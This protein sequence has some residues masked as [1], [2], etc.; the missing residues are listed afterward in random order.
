MSNRSLIN[1][2]FQI[3]GSIDFDDLTSHLSLAE[4]TGGPYLTGTLTAV[5]GS[6]TVTDVSNFFSISEVDSYLVTATGPDTDKIFR[7]LS[8]S[9]TNNAVIYPL[10]TASG[11]YSY[12]RYRYRNLEDDLNFL[13][14]IISSITGEINWH[15]I[16]DT[17]LSQTATHLNDST[18][19]LSEEGIQDIVSQ[20]L[21]PGTDISISYDDFSG[22]VTIS[23]TL[24]GTFTNHAALSNLDYASSG[25]TGFASSTELATLS[26]SLESEISE[27]ANL[28]HDHDDLYYTE[29]E[30]DSFLTTLSGAIIDQIPT[31][32]GTISNHAELN[33]LDYET[34]G[35]TGFQPAGD[36]TT[37]EDLLTISGSIVEQ[38]PTDYYTTGQVDTLLGDKQDVGDYATNTNLVLVSGS[39]QTQINNID[40]LPNQAGNAGKYLSTDG[41][42]PFWASVSGGGGTSDHAGLLNLDFASSGH[43]GFQPAGDYATRTELNTASGIIVSQ[44]PTD[45]YTTNEVNSLI[46]T[47]SGSLQSQIDA[48]D[49]EI[50]WEEI[51]NKPSVF[52]PDTHGNEAHT[53]AFATEDYVDT[54]ISTI[55]GGTFDHA[56]LVNLDFADSGHTGFQPSGDYTTNSDLINVSGTLSN[57]IADKADILHQHITNDITDFS[58]NVQDIV[59]ATLVPGNN[60]FITYNDVANTITISGAAGEGGGYTSHNLL[61]NLDFTN[62]GHTGFASSE[63]LEDAIDTLETS[64]TLTSGTLNTKIDNLSFYTESEI[65]ALFLAAAENLTSTSGVLQNQIDA[66]DTI[67]ATDASVTSVSGVLQADINIRSLSTHNHT[68]SSLSEKSYNSL[69]DK[70]TIP[71]D[72]YS[73]AVVDAKDAAVSGSLDTRI[74]ALEEDTVD[75]TEIQNKPATF[76]PSSH[77]HDD[78]YYTESEVDILLT[79]VSGNIINQIPSVSGYATEEY[80]DTSITAVS[81]SL[82]SQITLL[83]D[84]NDSG[85]GSTD[86]W[87]AEQILSTLIED[88][89]KIIYQNTDPIISDGDNLNYLIQTASGDIWCKDSPGYSEDV[90]VGGTPSSSDADYGSTPA[91]LFDND[92]NTVLYMRSLNFTT[93]P[94]WINYQFTAPESIRRIGLFPRNAYLGRFPSIFQV[95]AS[96]TGSFSGEETV[97]ASFNPE[98]PTEL[99]WYYFEFENSSSFTHYR[100]FITGSHEPGGYVDLSEVEMHYLSS[101]SW[102]K[103]WENN[104]VTQVELTTVSGHIVSQIPTDFYTTGQIDTLLLN[105]QD[106]GDYSTTAEL[107]TA[108]GILQ[109]QIDSNNDD[110]Q[111]IESIYTDT[112]EPTGFVNRSDSYLSFND[113]TE[114][115]TVSGTYS[116]YIH[117]VKHSISSPKSA[118]VLGA[119]LNLFYLD[120]SE[121]LQVTQSFSI[122][123][124]LRDN[125]YVAVVYWDDVDSKHIYFGDERHGIL[126]DWNLH[127]YH[128]LTEGTKYQSGLGLTDITSDINFEGVYNADDIQWT[129]SVIQSS[130]DDFVVSVA[131]N[132]TPNGTRSLDLTGSENN[133]IAQ[134]SRPAGNLDLTSFTNLEGYI[135]INLFDGSDNVSIYGWNTGTNSIVGNSVNISSYV[136]TSTTDEWQNFIIPLTDMNLD[137]ET[138]DAIRIQT[139]DS[140]DCYLDDIILY[141]SSN[142]TN[143]GIEIG[144][145]SGTIRD[146][147]LVHN[148]D[149]ISSGEEKFIVLYREGTNGWT[150]DATTSVPLITISGGGRLA[151]NYFNGSTWSQVIVPNNGYV[152]SHIFAT[153][154][155][156]YPIISVQ[157]QNSYTDIGAARDAIATEINSLITG[158]LPFEEFIAIGSLIAQT[159]DAYANSHKARFVYIDSNHTINWQDFRGLKGVST[160]GISVSSHHNLSNLATGD[161][162]PQYHNN[163]RGDARYYTQ[164]QITAISGTIVS[165]IPSDFNDLYYT[166]AELDTGQLDNR[167]Y[168]ENEITSLLAGKENVFSKNTAFNKNF[169]TISGTVCAGDD[170]R[171]SDSRT[172]VN[173]GNEAHT[174]IFITTSGV[175]FENLNINGDVGTNSSQV[176]SGDHSHTGVYDLAGTASSAVTSHENT[177]DHEIFITNTDLATTSGNIVSQIPTDYYTTG[178]VDGLISTISGSSLKYRNGRMFPVIGN[179]QN[180]TG[181]EDF[182]YGIDGELVANDGRWIT[183]FEPGPLMTDFIYFDNQMIASSSGINNDDWVT[184][185]IS[186]YSIPQDDFDFQFDFQF[187]KHSGSL[188]TS[189]D[190][191][192]ASVGSDTGWAIGV[193]WRSD[194]TFASYGWDWDTIFEEDIEY[195]GKVL[196]KLRMKRENGL[197]TVYVWN[198]TDQ[199]WEWDGNTDG[200]S[201][202]QDGTGLLIDEMYISVYHKGIGSSTIKIDNFIWNNLVVSGMPFE[203]LS[204]IW[205][206]DN[207]LI[208]EL[209]SNI[210]QVDSNEI[211]SYR[212][213]GSFVIPDDYV[214][215]AALTTVSGSLQEQIDSLDNLYATDLE[216]LTTSGVLQSNINTKADIDHNHTGVY[217]PIG[218]YATTADLLTLSGTLTEAINN[219]TVSGTEDTYGEEG[220]VTAVSGSN[221]VSVT[222]ASEKPDTSY[223]I[224]TS[225]INEV[226][227]NPSQYGFIIT[228]KQTTGFTVLFSSPF[229]SGNYKLNFRVGPFITYGSGEGSGYIT[230]AGVTFENLNTNGDVGTGAAQV[231]V[232]NHGHSADQILP[233]QT[234]HSGEYL[235]TNGSTSSWGTTPTNFGIS[236]SLFDTSTSI[237]TGSGIVYW[238]TPV[239]ANGKNLSSVVAAVD[240]AGSSGDTEIQI[241][242]GRAASY[243]DMLSVPVTISGSQYYSTNGTIDT[244]NDDINTGDRIFV[245]INN[246]STGSQ[247]LTV[248]LIFS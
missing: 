125:A 150:H 231:A 205:S 193:D 197:F 48:I 63:A 37:Q 206:E 157:G 38:I 136:N 174:S 242:R 218:D 141:T 105:K 243:V 160:G 129:M 1:Q 73:Q 244:N 167:Y 183:P 72:F 187:I 10:P 19:H 223:S 151:Y 168:T 133:D 53:T 229:D 180:F 115:L 66:L 117:G 185:A 248:T 142:P 154:D 57:A 240:T 178:E 149:G 49:Q 91:D 128:H 209:T 25:H 98:Y 11:D 16:P 121:T 40:P 17:N 83:P 104:A 143:S 33:N 173:H 172:P 214:T 203:P 22:T 213:I 78:R 113:S 7:I 12:T 64:I 224:S 222:F 186:Y 35:H 237:T 32:S 94:L 208:D 61:S 42:S 177:Y 77:T 46:A 204:T 43:I 234:G 131:Q 109:S 102:H 226:D 111:I 123:T 190:V 23:S 198:E 221:T 119:G 65:D 4:L 236:F 235:T 52:T 245:D 47:T 135:W 74:T 217:Q 196:S 132:N 134:F 34:S 101:Y 79:T 84:I 50:S 44:I 162:H 163:A 138:I 108:S 164:G 210:Y 137:G 181:Y 152:I 212:Y 120:S 110:I 31:L 147:D 216:L 107:V 82:Q 86:L 116:Y 148:I 215:T 103:I 194:N 228:D 232:G 93:T 139:T 81:G 30:I 26:G 233:S 161:D 158:D 97:L 75:W 92:T 127:A 88:T 54:A 80:V 191:E 8:C 20:M 6:S 225:L 14:S 2:K 99:T 15:L 51:S 59:A 176:A 169:G 45:F 201:L 207:L 220:T 24:S 241:R 89:S 230:A 238:A 145:A 60:I 246:V 68:L 195:P 67:Y 100:I 28:I 114:E 29:N 179:P 140:A 96:N 146:E 39:L 18:I 188:I 130:A 36:Y 9:G 219:I 199:Q 95:L 58:E 144:V 70:P 62:S 56:D 170:S 21:V 182:F 69:T 55:S 159:S 184:N 3:R 71:T 5:S 175:T 211:T 165:Q 112:S 156:E 247:G 106:A 200:L 189:V 85:S 155:V 41:N 76:T 124:I 166:E 171:L 90:C 153:N 202:V 13:R 192:L 87:S 126:W 239:P 227:L 122:E 27:K 118:A